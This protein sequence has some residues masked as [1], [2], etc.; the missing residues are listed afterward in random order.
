MAQ[1][2]L[3]DILRRVVGSLL[4][5]ELVE[6]VVLRDGEAYA[7]EN[8]ELGFG[9][10]IGGV[11]NLRL[12]HVELGALCHATRVSRIGL[13][14][15][16]FL[17]VADQNDVRIFGERINECRLKSRLQQH[18]RLADVLPS[19]DRRAVEQDPWVNRSS[20]TVLT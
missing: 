19:A 20:F 4:G 17:D 9:A 5:I 13:T 7:V 12:R 2:S 15:R 6:R 3:R 11:P 14:G 1:V 16:R 18:V 8:E 10:E